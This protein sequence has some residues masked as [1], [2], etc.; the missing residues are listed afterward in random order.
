MIC[1][2]GTNLSSL[3]KLMKGP[4]TP[5]FYHRCGTSFCQTNLNTI[6]NILNKQRSQNMATLEGLLEPLGVHVSFDTSLAKAILL[7]ALL[8]A[9][10]TAGKFI[11]SYIRVLLSLF[12]LPVSSVMSHIN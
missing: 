11:L 12:I 3:D 2:Y 4:L 7:F 9:L 1:D 5:T 8:L 6:V 10:Y